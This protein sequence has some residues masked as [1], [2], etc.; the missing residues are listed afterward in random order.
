MSIALISSFDFNVPTSTHMDQQ[1]GDNDEDESI[2]RFVVRWMRLSIN[3]S[4]EKFYYKFD[5]LN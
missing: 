2:L 3:Y 5:M 1:H 4:L